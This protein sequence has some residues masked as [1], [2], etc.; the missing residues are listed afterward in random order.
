MCRLNESRTE[1]ENQIICTTRY[2]YDN[3]VVVFLPNMEI[4]ELPDPWQVSADYL[5]KQQQGGA[6]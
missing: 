5:G 6:G 2:T 4:E 1:K 3:C